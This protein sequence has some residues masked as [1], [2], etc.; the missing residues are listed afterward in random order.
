MKKILF[1]LLTFTAALVTQ[2]AD[3]VE[4]VTSPNGKIKVEINF[5]SELKYSVFDEGKT[6]L[7]DSRIGLTI[8]NGPKVGS[9]P[10]LK[11]KTQATINE[12][13]PSPFYRQPKVQNNCNEIKLTMSDGFTLTFRAYDSGVA[14]R[15]S[16]ALK[17]PS[18][19]IVE[20]ELAE[21]NFPEDHSLLVHSMLLNHRFR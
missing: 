8:K 7:K 21:F 2:A 1:L 19:M 6:L 16:S 17:K 5:G 10:V 3:K 9:N 20:N 12:E 18:E 4:R 13:I 14:Y 11:K 15:L